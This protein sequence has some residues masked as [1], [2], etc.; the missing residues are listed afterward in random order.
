[1][2]RWFL[3]LAALSLALFSVNLYLNGWGPALSLLPGVFFFA[4][5]GWWGLVV[6]SAGDGP[7]GDDGPGLEGAGRPVPAGSGPR[8]HLIAGK[9]FP[10]LVKTHSWPVD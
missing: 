9:E 2:R 1:L 8:H 7:D 5:L 6:P 4:G 10:P 3:F